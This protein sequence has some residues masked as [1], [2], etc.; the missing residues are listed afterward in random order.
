MNDN[1]FETY[2]SLEGA[3]FSTGDHKERAR[4][5]WDA[6]LKAANVTPI[7]QGFWLDALEFDQL[8]EEREEAQWRDQLLKT[9]NPCDRKK[10]DA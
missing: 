1:G 8:K 9:M 7:A 2:W 6:A 10:G 4:H 3:R 5:A